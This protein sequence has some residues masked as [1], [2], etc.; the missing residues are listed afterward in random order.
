MCPPNVYGTVV[1]LYGAGTDGH[2]S[3]G[4]EDTVL[5]VRAP[6]P[7][8]RVRAALKQSAE[9][10]NNHLKE[11]QNTSSLIDARRPRASW[12]R[13]SASPGLRAGAG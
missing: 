1:K 13:A 2:D 10:A 8:S 11:K 12:R 3:Y 9:S 7:L 5:E 4:V 6:L